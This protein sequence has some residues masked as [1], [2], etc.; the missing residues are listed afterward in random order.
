[1]K[2]RA[3]NSK[4]F[5]KTLNRIFLPGILALVLLPAMILP[6]AALSQENQADE[7]ITLRQASQQWMQVGIEQYR[8]NQFADAERSFLRARVFQNYLTDTERRLLNE[9]IKNARIAISEGKQASAVTMPADDPAEPNEPAKAEAVVEKLEQ[10]I[11][12]SESPKEEKKEGDEKIEEAPKA[13]T[14]QPAEIE[15]ESEVAVPAIKTELTES[16]QFYTTIIAQLEQELEVQNLQ[17]ADAEDTIQ[18]QAQSLKEIEDKLKA[19]TQALAEAQQQAQIQVQSAQAESEIRSRIEAEYAEAALAAEAKAQKL[20][21]L[22]ASEIKALQQKLQA[23]E[24][25]MSKAKA[26]ARVEIEERLTAVTAELNQQKQQAAKAVEP[27]VSK[28]QEENGAS[29]QVIVIQDKS[30]GARFLRSTDWLSNNSSVLAVTGL[31]FLAVLVTISK[32]QGASKISSA[33]LDHVPESSSYIGAKLGGSKKSKRAVKNSGDKRL[34][35]TAR[36]D[37]KPKSSKQPTEHWMKDWKELHSSKVSH[38][39]KPSRIGKK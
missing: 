39:D 14:K 15:I 13:G 32:L 2:V 22:H 8:S 6:Q 9:L 28:I 30:L 3:M 29:D 37:P 10:K 5:V 4:S 38:R 24:E 20:A 25:E 36:Q 19:Q 11:R 31:L 12:E 33:Y 35:F 18:A 34:T 26:K 23:Q 7:Q 1:M 17:M 21:E 16:E 27:D